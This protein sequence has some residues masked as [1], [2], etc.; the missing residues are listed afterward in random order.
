MVPDMTKEFKQLPSPHP[1]EFSLAP[2]VAKPIIGA[3]ILAW[4]GLERDMNRFILTERMKRKFV[5]PPE[6]KLS[7]RFR[8]NL[9]EWITLFLGGGGKEAEFIRT[10][11][12]LLQIIRNDIAHNIWTLRLDTQLGLAVNVVQEND[13]FWQEEED[14]I[15]A[16]Q[17]TPPPRNPKAQ[18]ATFRT[19]T[20]F[21]SDLADATVRMDQL[22]G[23]M[24]NAEA[25]H[26]SQEYL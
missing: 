4:T 12:R 9:K 22:A 14:W 13:R 8:E 3:V 10:E 16:S 5:H 18:P 17:L 1:D 7:H 25:R 23:V 26:F 11:A 24:R 21:G 6:R 19:D 15:A 2:Q 20:C